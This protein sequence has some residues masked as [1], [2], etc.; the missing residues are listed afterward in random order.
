LAVAIYVPA[1]IVETV[2]VYV[3]TIPTVLGPVLLAHEA[4]PDVPASAKFKAPDGAA[5]PVD[6]ATVAVKMT[7]PPKVSAPV[8]LMDTAGAAF[9]TS[10][11]VEELT[12]VI[13]L[14]AASP[15]NVKLAPYVPASDATTL[16]VYVETLLRPAGPVVAAQF[17]MPVTP[18]IDH[19]PRAVGE[20]APV[21]PVTVAVK[22][23]V[24]PRGAVEALA[25]IEIVGTTAVTTVKAP[26]VGEVA[27]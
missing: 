10:V 3:V 1:A 13:A 5:A 6:P 25:V 11:V 18:V 15:A 23:I 17:V 8:E 2:Q 4:T 16:Q 7:E 21:G 19:V 27:K 14:Y 22:V 12:A 9:E 20:T 24:E 26:E